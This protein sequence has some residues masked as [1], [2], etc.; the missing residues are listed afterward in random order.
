MKIY[1]IHFTY[2]FL[3]I[4]G[5]SSSLEKKFHSDN[6]SLLDEIIEEHDNVMKQMSLISS[7]KNQLLEHMSLHP[8]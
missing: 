2:I 4:V 1:I 5:C 3:I 8:H 6:M 7:L